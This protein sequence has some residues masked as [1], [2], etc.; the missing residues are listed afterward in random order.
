MTIDQVN[1]LDKRIAP[2]TGFADE[3][4]PVKAKTIRWGRVSRLAAV[5]LFGWLVLS[6]TAARLL[7]VKTSLTSADAI[8]VMGGS[9]TYIERTTW[10]ARLYRE[11]RAP[12]IILTNDGMRGG[13][14]EREERNLPYYELA[15]N[16]LRAQGVPA[17]KIQVISAAASGTY[18]ESL[19]VRAF[20]THNGL[21]SLLIVTSAYH[22]RRALWSMRRAG[23]GSSINLGV[24]PAPP[25]W[26]TPSPAT[27]WLHPWGWKVVGGEYVKTVYYLVRH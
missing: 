14:N 10:A 1:T 13:W 9:A 3:A 8:V 11:G 20:A 2:M 27:W 15:A 21:K 18:E 25:G 19:G 24:D 5:C 26:Q 16:E 22:S 12:M 7:I 4:V 23:Q 6:W 17:D